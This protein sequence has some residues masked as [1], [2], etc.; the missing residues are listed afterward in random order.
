MAATSIT[1]LAMLLPAGTRVETTTPAGA[2]GGPC[3]V[4]KPDSVC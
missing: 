2:D 1:T 4:G 3:P